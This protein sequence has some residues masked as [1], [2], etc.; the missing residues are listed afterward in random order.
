MLLFV[1]ILV[2]GRFMI[3]FLMFG[4]FF[5]IFLGLPASVIVSIVFKV[6]KKKALIPAVCIP[7]SLVVGLIFIVI[8]SNLYSQTDE[9]K[10]SIAKKEQSELEQLKQENQN[11]EEYIKDLE[12][13]LEYTEKEED[14]PIESTVVEQEPT[15]ES[16]IAQETSEE[17]E[18]P[19]ESSE[20]VQVEEMQ[21]PT[22]NFTYKDMTVKYLRHEV[23][24]D[25]V[26]QTVLVVYYEFTNNS[27]ENKTFDYAFSDTCF[28]NGVEVEH[29]YWHVNDESKNSGKEIKTGTTITVASSFV[30]GESRDDI[31]LEITP[32]MRDKVLFE[33]TL[34][35]E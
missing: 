20:V 7:I 12:K 28:Q 35:L 4:G 6:R 15:S 10:E 24:V 1:K 8:G 32:F 13:R 14:K 18:K 23:M 34:E 16:V 2:E 21:E 25:S 27:K 5:L 11:Q 31:E 29:S 22:Y 26:D 33:K 3:N 30:L 17:E 9:Y 19:I